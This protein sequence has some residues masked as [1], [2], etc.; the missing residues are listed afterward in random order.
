MKKHLSTRRRA[1]KTVALSL[2]L[3]TCLASLAQAP[4]AWPSKPVRLLVTSPAGTAPDI[5][6]R[7]VADKLAQIWGQPVV[8]ENR[9]GAGG[10]I[11]LG[12]LKASGNDNHSFAFVPASILTLSPYMYK[13]SNIDI[14]QELIPV[15]LM[16]MS[17]MMV[18]TNPSLPVASLADLVGLANKQVDGLVA[19]VPSQ[20]S[21][22]HLTA[23]LL[24]KQMGM[25]IR[26]IP[27]SNSGQAISA[28]VAGDAQVVIDG[29]PPLEA[30]VKGGRLKAVAVFSAQRLPGRGDLAT[31]AESVQGLVVNGW[32][33]VVA[34]KG[35]PSAVIDRVNQDFGKVVGMPDVVARMDTFGV[36]PTPKYMTA[37]EFGGFWSSERLRW[38]KAL[39]SVGAQSNQ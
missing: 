12:Q 26:V 3:S 5:M 14:V 9:P 28:V 23:D 15:A 22:P 16:G 24:S 20:F 33:G 32:F 18:A 35:T 21:L 39:V 38:E 37:T 7:L 13:S 6:A 30:M 10:Q 11:G 34:M 17:P 36:Y 29:I 27:Y 1:L 4:S 8:V 25:P 31:A 19:A 2:G